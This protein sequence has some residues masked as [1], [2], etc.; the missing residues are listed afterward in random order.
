[1]DLKKFSA[2]K[3]QVDQLQKQVSRSEGSLETLKTNLKKSFYCDSVEA[4]KKLLVKLEKQEKELEKEFDQQLEKFEEK[5]AETL[6][7]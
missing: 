6:G 3:D 1:M 2:L 4:G 5:Y 7:E